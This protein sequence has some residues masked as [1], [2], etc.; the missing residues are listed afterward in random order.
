[1]RNE[2]F[3]PR[4]LS[5]DLEVGKEDGRIHAFGAVR[6]DT[7]GKDHGSGSASEL[8][9][10]DALADG[11]SFLLGHNL[12]A[13]DLPYLRAAKPDLRLLELPVIDT[14]RLSPLAFPRN[15]YHRLVKHYQDG[16]LMRGRINAPELDARLA[17]EVFGEQREALRKAE[18][19]LLTAWHWLTTP[20]PDGVDNAL[21]EFFADL[22]GTPRPA[23]PEAH[24]AIGRRLEGAACATHARKA[25]AEAATAGRSLGPRD[26]PPSAG[27]TTGHRPRRQG[28]GVRPRRRAGRWLEPSGTRR[29]GGGARTGVRAPLTERLRAIG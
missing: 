7:V 6:G 24:A 15:P 19:A 20:E 10:L 14:L 16:A 1:M 21:D 22:R 9:R 12:I 18:P 13:F 8:A 3:R 4:C 23:D 27:A 11:V 29:G 26:S 17:L 28:A 2:P 5:L 25:V